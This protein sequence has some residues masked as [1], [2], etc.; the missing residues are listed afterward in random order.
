MEPE[1]ETRVAIVPGSMKKLQKAGFEVIVEKGAGTAANYSDSEYTDAGAS[2]GSRKDVMACDVVISIRLPET[3]EL[4]KGQIV[5]CVA[6]PF[7][8][9][10][11]VQACIDGGVTLMSMDMIPRRLSRACLLY[12]SPS[13]RD[14]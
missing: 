12:T 3:S 10:A 8:H 9:P 13:P 1:G 11:K 14:G 7:R 4:S 2:V 5:A 6:D